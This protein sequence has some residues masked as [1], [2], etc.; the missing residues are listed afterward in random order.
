PRQALECLL[1]GCQAITL[2]VDV[3]EQ[4]LSAPAV[5]AAVEKFEQDWQGAFGSNL[6]G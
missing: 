4:F 3:A 2:P 1:A 5:Q 6:L